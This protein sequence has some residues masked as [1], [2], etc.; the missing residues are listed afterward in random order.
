MSSPAGDPA[1]PGEAWLS[2]TEHPT[3]R[4]DAVHVWCIP[5]AGAP[6][7]VQA[8]LSA[9]ERARAAR[10]R[11]QKD[12]ERYILAHG[13]KRSILARYLGLE[14]GGVRFDYGAYGKPVVADSYRGGRLGFNLSYSGGVALLAVG[15]GRD[16]GVDVEV[17]REDFS[18]E[19]IVERFFSPA[20]IAAMRAVP[21][22]ARRAAFFDHWTRKEAVVKAAGMGL[23]MPLDTLDVTMGPGDTSLVVETRGE[24]GGSR[25]WT[26]RM[27]DVGAGYSAA[28]A[29][30]GR[31]WQLYQYRWSWV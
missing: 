5:A 20:E 26:A 27:L 24:G 6:D 2:P 9:D 21:G 22:E 14:P 15:L 29:V 8:L 12:R 10:F 28:L 25:R 16:V 18:G 4:R 13:A 19:D 30:E 1:C 3:L 7:G 31:G 17:I 23:S 11:F